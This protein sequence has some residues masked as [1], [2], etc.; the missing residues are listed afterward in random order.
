MDSLKVVESTD[1]FC[2][3]IVTE[4]KTYRNKLKLK[5]RHSFIY[6]VIKK[7]GSL[8]EAKLTKNVQKLKKPGC[9][10]LA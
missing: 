7:S 10:P 8:L 2:N 4:N 6:I 1:K 9:T 5:K 3:F